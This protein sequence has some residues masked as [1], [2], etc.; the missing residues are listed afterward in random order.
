MV[1]RDPAAGPAGPR[2]SG[3]E[4]RDALIRV[5]PVLLIAFA[6]VGGIY[7]GVF[8]PTEGAAV[9]AVAMLAA[10][11]RDRHAG[12]R[13]HR[14]SLR[15]TARDDGDDLHRPARRGD[16][17]RLPGDLRAAAARG[18][19]DRRGGL[20]PYAVLAAL[21]LFYIVLGGVMD[22]LAML[23]LTLP[24]FFPVVMG[25]RFRPDSEETAIWFGILVLVIVGIGLTAPPIGL[26]VFVMKAI[27]GGRRSPRSIAASCRSSPATWSGWCCWSFPGPRRWRLVRSGLEPGIP[28][29]SS[30]GG[31]DAHPGGDRRR[32]PR[33][34]PL[35]QLLHLRGIE[36][37]H[38]REP[39]ARGDRGDDP[40]RRA[41]AGHRRPD[42]RD[43]RRRPA[44]ARG[45]R[46]PRLEIRFAG[47]GHRIDLQDL[48]GGRVDHR[49]RPARG[50]EGPDQLRLGDGGQIR[51]RPRPQAVDDVDGDRPRSASRPR[52]AGPRSWRATSSPAATA[53]TACAGRRS[54]R[55]GAHRTISAS[56]PPAGSASW[57]RRRPPPTS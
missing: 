22:E 23:L 35:A 46:P 51:S 12:L 18:R 21:L 19:A 36:V 5:W 38:R 56:I 54:R 42:D 1:R 55:A 34:A 32:R 2:L 31:P 53:A 52:R 16:V 6:V 10:R 47:R 7:G 41:R 26:N 45:L 30:E 9:G 48:A 20:P 8:T 24:V 17:Q 49:L 33:G 29:I 3:A 44:Q 40:R 28:C 13:R 14:Q 27:A 15:Q 50:A 39:L 43:R 11:A 25:A 37:D 57:P 4:R